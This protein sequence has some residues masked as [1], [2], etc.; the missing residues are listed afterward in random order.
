MT[1]DEIIQAIHAERTRQERLH[2]GWDPSE[3]LAILSEEFGEV[4]RATYE[5]NRAVDD[6]TYKYWQRNF[7]SELIQVAAV[8]F[9]IL[10]YRR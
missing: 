10:E 3:A 4:G 8:C 5:S 6:E 1:R 9:R 7:E 2:P